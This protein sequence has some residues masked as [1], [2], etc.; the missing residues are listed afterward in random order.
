[1]K[2]TPRLTA[3]LQP[4]V[5]RL[6]FMLFA[7]AFICFIF[8][9]YH[10]GAWR[11]IFH[12][13]K[14]F[15]EGKRLKPFLASFGPYSA[16]AFVFLQVV[17]VVVA[18]VPGEVTGFVG[19]LLFG[20]LYGTLLSTAGL[21]A[22]ALI[23]FWLARYFG[24]GLVRRIVKKEYFDRFD[25]FMATHKALNITFVFFLIPGFPKDS[26]CYLL[27]L[28]RMRYLDFVLMNVCGRLPGTIILCMQ[29]NAIR[30]GQFVSFWLLLAG[31]LTLTVSLYF[32]RN[33][34]VRFF[35][36]C[37]RV[38]ER[39]KGDEGGETYPVVSKDIE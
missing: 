4:F 21:T 22:G 38:L 26:L 36:S 13:Y 32:G 17:Q 30:H 11:F 9:L 28:T 29:G 10:E 37:W 3:R 20:N 16:L 7:A 18:P 5:L 15:F 31:S 23:A 24:S 19:G 34:I 14:Y 12:Y 27:G 1:M 8:Y 6:L 2:E 33:F 35:A 25:A 39:K